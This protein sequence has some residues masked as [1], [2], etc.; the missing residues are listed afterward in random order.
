MNNIIVVEGNNK[1]IFSSKKEMIKQFLGKDFLELDS[2]EK[3]KKLKLKT[4]INSTY[5]GI[6]IKDII[7]GDIIDDIT[8]KQYIIFDEETFLLSLAKNNDIVIYEN[9]KSNLFIK[10]INKDN[11]ER[12]EKKYIRVN[13]FVN[14]ILQNKIEKLNLK[15]DIKRNDEQE[16]V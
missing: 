12:I 9:E 2:S 1:Y 11:L 15:N 8:Q 16:R 14:I 4:L 5:K 7:Q 10:D 3:Y 6:P 13:D